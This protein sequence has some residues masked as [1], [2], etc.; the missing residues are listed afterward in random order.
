MSTQKN[1][2]LEIVYDRLLR[3]RSILL[4]GAL[5]AKLIG[6]Y[7]GL[8]V[9]KQEIERKSYYMELDGVPVP[10]RIKTAT[11]QMVISNFR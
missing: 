7:G 9:D 11:R 1:C 5:G 2:R 8:Q 10:E 3:Y 4:L 6:S